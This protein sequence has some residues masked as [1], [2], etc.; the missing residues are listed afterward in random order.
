MIFASR[1]DGLCPV[2]LFQNHDSGQM[3]GKGHGTHGKLK[4]CPLF[5][6]RRHA[7]GRTNEKTGAALSGVFYSSYFFRKT[8]TGKR[9]SLRGKDTEPGT[10][11][12]FGK[13]QIRFLFQACGNLG[14]GRVFRKPHLRQFQQRKLAIPTQ[15][16]LVF[17]RGGNIEFFLQF[18]H[19]DQRNIKHKTTPKFLSLRGAKQRGNLL[20]IIG[21]FYHFWGKK[22]IIFSCFRGKVSGGVIMKKKE[23]IIVTDPF[24]S[25]TGLV[26]DPY[27]KPVQDADDL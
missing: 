20:L 25:Y 7:E 4:I 23:E 18:S 6:P 11:G 21:L 22:A 14:R 13:D 1:L 10:L 26:K 17:L 12:N 2:K 15:P 19:G 9:F 16:L 8:L 27:E 3:V 24:G 5:D